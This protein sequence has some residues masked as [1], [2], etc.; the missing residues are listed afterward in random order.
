M[1][2]TRQVG[3]REAR[4]HVCRASRCPLRGVWRVTLYVAS[5]PSALFTLFVFDVVG[6]A[7]ALLLTSRRMAGLD[8][9]YDTT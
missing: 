1:L 4:E 3:C 7:C 5:T 6:S 8:G 2:G 9:G